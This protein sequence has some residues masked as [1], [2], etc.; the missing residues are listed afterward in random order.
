MDVPSR[1]SKFGVVCAFPRRIFGNEAPVAQ[2]PSSSEEKRLV[3]LTRQPN[4]TVIFHPSLRI[5][6][7]YLANQ[8]SQARAI[9]SGKIRARF[10]SF[11][12]GMFSFAIN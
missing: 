1:L 4:I 8:E 12:R 11:S 2:R 5:T 3:M 9:P 6:D 7:S 10:E